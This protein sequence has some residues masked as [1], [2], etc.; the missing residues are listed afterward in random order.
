MAGIGQFL[1]IATDRFMMMNLT[2]KTSTIAK[3]G[4]S[5]KGR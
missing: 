4:Q 3:T 2:E 1:P 5:V